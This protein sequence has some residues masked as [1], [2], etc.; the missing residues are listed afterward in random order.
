MTTFL[1][2]TTIGVYK[3]GCIRPIRRF[4]GPLRTLGDVKYRTADYVAWYNQ[5]RLMHALDESDPPM[6]RRSTIPNT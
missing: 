6:L 2:E 5:W 4:A 3:D 1:A